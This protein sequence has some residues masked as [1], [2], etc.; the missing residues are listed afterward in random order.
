MAA[1]NLTKEMVPVALAE[2][3]ELAEDYL[4]RLKE[5]GVYGEVKVCDGYGR[6][7]EA[8]LLV[9][10]DK[11]DEAFWIIEEKVAEGCELGISP[12]GGGG[13]SIQAA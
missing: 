6:V 8:M 10:A 11:L 7:K 5:H 1:N 13:G 2:D 3:R 4:E 9:A 12:G